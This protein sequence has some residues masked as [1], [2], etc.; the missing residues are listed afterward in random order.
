MYKYNVKS[1]EWRELY[2][3]I[4]TANIWTS[5]FGSTINPK[6]NLIYVYCKR[7]L[8][9][10]DVDKNTTRIHPD[11]NSILEE[12]AEKILDGQILPPSE[13]RIL[14]NSGETKHIIAQTRPKFSLCREE[15]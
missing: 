15:N 7:G 13:T 12:R 8:Y 3:D 9:E 11:D 2:S 1:N 5:D 6:N 14:T 4:D 10:I